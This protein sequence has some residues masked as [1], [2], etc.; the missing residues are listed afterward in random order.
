MA[1]SDDPQPIKGFTPS[2]SYVLSDAQLETDAV[3]GLLLKAEAGLV[4]L[5]SILVLLSI[6]LV[7]GIPSSARIYRLSYF[8]HAAKLPAYSA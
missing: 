2:G 1:G 8:V 6:I 4:S 3:V 7:R 5:A